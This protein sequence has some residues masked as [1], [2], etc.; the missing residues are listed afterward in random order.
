[1]LELL[2][3]IIS[4][5]PHSKGSLHTISQGSLRCYAYSEVFHDVLSVRWR[6]NDLGLK[7]GSAV[8]LLADNKYEWMLLDLACL[9]LGIILVPFDPK[10]QSAPHALIQ[11]YE[12]DYLF[13]DLSESVSHSNAMLLHELKNHPNTLG[14]D[15]LPFFHYEPNSIVCLKF[16]SGTTSLP[17]GIP[18]KAQNIEDC[19]FVIQ[20]A[21]KH[22]PN[23]LILSFLPL[24]LLQQRY[25]LYSS[26]LF[27]IPLAVVSYL[28]SFSAISALGP[29]VVMA[30]PHFLEVLLQRYEQACIE[31]RSAGKPVSKIAPTI[32][33]N[34]LRYLWSGSAPIS[35]ELLDKYNELDIPVYQGYGTAETGILTKNFPGSNRYGS[36]GRVLPGRDIKISEAGEILARPCAELN[37]HYCEGPVSRRGERFLDDHGFF[38]TGD[39]GYFDADGFLYITGRLK[40][41]IVLSSG[42]KINPEPIEAAVV[43]HAGMNVCVLFASPSGRLIAVVESMHSSEYVRDLIAR[44][45]ENLSPEE[46]IGDYF[47]VRSS[48]SESGLRNAQGKIVRTRVY[49]M[50]REELSKFGVIASS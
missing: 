13:Y 34:R 36:V 11:H 33:G 4:R 35:T 2:N 3:S 10:I 8:G 16:T 21:F 30:V 18:A 41:M 38:A 25:F 5:M 43:A 24:Y 28:Y 49:S 50:Y 20:D 37:S 45:N 40:N 39:L 46:R 6:L 44:L 48:F 19:V 42:R 15:E 23:D 7:H 31:A 14:A 9:S 26:I 47:L 22:G 29:T 1:M 17:K 27:D 12:L 32:F